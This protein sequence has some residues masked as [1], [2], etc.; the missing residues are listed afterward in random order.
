MWI[1]TQRRE[2]LSWSGQL[3]SHCNRFATSVPLAW[4]PVPHS[5]PL[6]AR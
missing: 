6:K 3:S 4:G 2:F 5:S 1:V